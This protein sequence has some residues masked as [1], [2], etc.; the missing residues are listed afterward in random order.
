M[1]K[2]IFRSICLVALAVLIASVVLIMGV[3]YGYFTDMQHD[4]LRMQTELAAQGVNHEGTAYFDQLSARDY[5]ITLIEPDGRV[6]YDSE[7]DSGEME[8]HLEREEVQEALDSGYGESERYSSTL[9]EKSLYSAMV[10]DDGSILRMSVSQSG[11]LTLLLG[12]LQPIIVVLIAAIALS[13][14]L[15]S[16]LS[17]RIVKPLNELDLDDPL[18]NEGY[19][20]LSPL[21]LRV[22][23]QQKQL[24]K[25]SAELG[26]RQD[27]F[28]AVTAS[29]SEGLVLLNDKGNI[30]SINPAASRFLDTDQHSV[31]ENILTVNRSLDLQELLSKALNGDQAEKIMDLQ[32]GHYQVIASPVI[33]DNTVSGIALLIFDVTDKENSEQMRREFTANVSHELRTPLH[34]ISG[35]AELLKNGMVKTADI[36]PIASK[37]YDEAQRMVRLVEDIINLS[38]LDEGAG[39][40][41]REKIDLFEAAKATALSLEPEAESADVSISVTGEPAVIEGIPQ[42]I[43]GIVYNLCDNA[44]KYNHKGG[45]VSVIVRKNDDSAVLTVR[46]TGIGIPAED[47]N[48]VFERFYRVDKSHS[49]EVGGTGLGLSIVKHSARIHGARI[50]LESSVGE[51]TTVTVKFPV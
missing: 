15:A 32:E 38:H 43:G 12:M 29:M 46:D 1:T 40:M 41:A 28:A 2:K 50:S 31:G 34:S 27:E 14:L 3:L 37:I 44:I 22:Y 5:R 6:I 7:A 9:M 19:D 33:S 17:K 26:Q 35:Y 8:N 39:D 16:R 20:E 10:L 25:Q 45:S 21:L 49:K 23:S 48:R 4:Q 30:L 13:L 47:Q 51:G 18:S 11:I 36:R 24:K 42:L